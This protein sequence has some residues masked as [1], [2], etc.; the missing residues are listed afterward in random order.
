[1]KRLVCLLLSLVLL[2]CFPALAEE[3]DEDEFGESWEYLE[4][5]FGYSLWYNAD[6]LT[7]WTDEWEGETAE[8]LCPW[9]DESGVAVLICRGSRFSAALWQDWTPVAL[10][11]ADLYLDVPYE[12]TAYTDGEIISEQ[13][14][15]SGADRDYVFIL[16]YETEDPENWA[17]LFRDTLSGLEFPNQPAENESFRLDFFQ[18][19]AAGMQFIDIKLDL[20]AAVLALMPLEEV[21]DFTLEK[22]DWNDFKYTASP[23]CVADV[24]SPGQNLRI[25]TDIPDAMPNLRFRYTDGRGNAQCWYITQSGRDGSL[26]LLGEND[27]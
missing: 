7:F 16:Q 13:W 12:M 11:N 26:M 18:G 2:C 15:V 23:V 4:S 5:R 20:D 19:G 24:L 1:M 27:L 22:L 9:E 10:E 3:E 8:M 25:Y 17:L 21:T 6:Q 14:I